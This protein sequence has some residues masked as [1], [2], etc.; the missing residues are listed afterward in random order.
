MSLYQCEVECHYRWRETVVFLF[1]NSEVG[2]MN[3]I[4]GIITIT[5]QV[6]T[7]ACSNFHIQVGHIELYMLSWRST[8]PTYD[9]DALLFMSLSDSLICDISRV[10]ANYCAPQWLSV[11]GLALN[12]DKSKAILLWTFQHNP[13][14]HHPPINA[15]DA[16]IKKIESLGLLLHLLFRH[17]YSRSKFLHTLTAVRHSCIK[18]IYSFLRANIHILQR[19][20]TV[21]QGLYSCSTRSRDVICTINQLIKFKIVSMAFKLHA[22]AP[23]TIR[24]ILWQII[25]SSFD[26]FDVL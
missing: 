12:P 25:G 8:S 1:D 13:H 24:T 9:N 15:A 6:G 19:L 23:I 11:I 14:Q 20:I 22:T 26:V 4:A 3:S 17:A 2:W 10:F 7:N 21:C 5:W 18:T 16:I